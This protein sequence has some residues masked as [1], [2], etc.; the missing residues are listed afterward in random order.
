MK[1]ILN[2]L[3][4]ILGIVAIAIAVF[5]IYAR[6]HDG[7]LEIV[8]GGPFRS[9]ELNPT[10]ESWEFIADRNTV[11]FQ[12]LEPARSRTVWL[13]V[14][15]ERLFIV[16]GY[17]NTG[18]GSLWKHWPYYL[19]NDD[20]IILRIDGQLY[21]QR[22][23]RITSGPEIVPVL[24]EFNRKYGSGEATDPA[25]VTSGDTWMFEVLPRR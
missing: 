7:P 20:R 5:L 10:P 6:F 25:T 1:K 2:W 14:Y 9:G 19:E 11:E 3:G 8:A 15:D 23:E 13:G 21:E 4:V 16:S 24:N 22:L 18:I 17:M 12:T